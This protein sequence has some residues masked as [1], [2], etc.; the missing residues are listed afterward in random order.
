MFFLEAGI[1]HF[2]SLNEANKIVNF[3]LKSSFSNLT[4]MLHNKNFYK[5]YKKKKFKFSTPRK[6]FIKSY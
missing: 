4:F 3:F 5:I 2:G 1:N 6:T